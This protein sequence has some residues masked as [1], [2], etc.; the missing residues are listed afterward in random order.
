MEWVLDLK[1]DS[2]NSVRCLLVEDTSFKEHMGPHEQGRIYIEM[3]MEM[4]IG[5]EQIKLDGK[6]RK[7]W[8]PCCF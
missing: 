2:Q 5:C 1:G 6:L 3:D 7:T 8:I 4:E